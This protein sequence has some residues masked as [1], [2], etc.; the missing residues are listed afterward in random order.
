MVNNP[1]RP[2]FSVFIISGLAVI[3]FSHFLFQ[4]FGQTI[5][6]VILTFFKEI[7]VVVVIFVVF[8]FALS[9]ILNA[10]PHNTPK[11]YLVVPFDVFGKQTHI[12]GLRTEFKTH[13]VAWSFM[14][15]YKKNYPLN[16]FALVG[17]IQKSQKKIIFR[18]I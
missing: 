10:R 18:Y 15:Q 13:D 17:D 8:V 4:L 11:K 12:D 7:G 3:A 6:G 16:N 5:P 14:N 1:F 9:W 2:T